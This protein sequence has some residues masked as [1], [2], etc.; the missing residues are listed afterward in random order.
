LF[1]GTPGLGGAG[2]PP[3]DG[4]TLARSDDVA[5]IDRT[6]GRR[7]FGADP[8]GY[9]LARPGYPP[10]VYDLLRDCC[11]LRPG[12]RTFEIGP[13][14]GQATRHLLRMG[15]APLVAI[16]PD[17]RLAVFLRAHPDGFGGAVEVRVTA[18]EDVELSS[19]SFDLGVA[20]TS[21]HWLDGEAAPRK[22][23][24][25]LRPGGWWAM[26]WNVFG[27]PHRPDEFHEVTQ[28]LLAGLGRSPSA[29][30]PRRPPYALDVDARVAELRAAEAFDEF[31]Y[32][33]IRWTVTFDA[34]GIRAIFAT[35]SEVTRLAPDRRERLLDDL[36][37]VA[38]TRFGGRVEKPMVTPVYTCRRR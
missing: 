30:E 24:R 5:A 27:D 19:G 12:T 1:L 8:A 9:D 21:F 23:A 35:F 17:E 11:G 37:A 13:G 2:K 28:A 29:G 3:D 10:R 4:R 6:E 20:A 16:E 31:A 36:A 25:A 32:E 26:W 14:T 22:I 34:A 38:A 15:A 7:A 18:F 33:T